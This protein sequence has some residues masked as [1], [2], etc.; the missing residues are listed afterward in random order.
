MLPMLQCKNFGQWFGSEFEQDIWSGRNSGLVEAIVLISRGVSS[1]PSSFPHFWYWFRIASSSN[2]IICHRISHLST[3]SSAAHTWTLVTTPTN[4][5]VWTDWQS[6]SNSMQYT[7]QIVYF[8][9]KHAQKG[10]HLVR[11]HSPN[12]TLRWSDAVPGYLLLEAQSA[13]MKTKSALLLWASCS[14]VTSRS[15]STLLHCCVLVHP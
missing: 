1:F 15:S 3:W 14:E 12:C 2:T 13:V 8:V 9:C 7:T 5:E 10:L 6:S 11:S 4:Q